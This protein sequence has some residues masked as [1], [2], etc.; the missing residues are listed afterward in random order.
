M[1]RSIG[2]VMGKFIS[3][4]SVGLVCAG[5]FCLVGSVLLVSPSKGK[6]PG[7]ASAGGASDTLVAQVRALDARLLKIESLLAEGG[8]SDQGE[9]AT[10][11]QQIHGLQSLVVGVSKRLERHEKNV[12]NRTKTKDNVVK[13]EKRVT[14]KRPSVSSSPRFSYHVVTQGETLYRIS[15]RY[16]ISEH[17]LIRLNGLKDRTRIYVGQRLRVM[18]T[19]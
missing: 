6:G 9:I 11:K 5:L 8:R 2:D 4:K 19:K 1:F 18:D 14:P 3:L 16:H 17:E 10:L 12:D 7:P 13:V 15:K